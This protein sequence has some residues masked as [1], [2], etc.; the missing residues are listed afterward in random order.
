MGP[1]LIYKVK[2]KRDFATNMFEGT[3][4]HDAMSLQFVS[5]LNLKEAVDQR[6]MQSKLVPSCHGSFAGFPCDDVSKQH[7]QSRTSEHRNTIKDGSLRTGKVFQELLTW[8]QKDEETE[9]GFLEN[10]ADL[11]LPPLP[12][13]D[14]E[15][16]DMANPKEPLPSNLDYVAHHMDKDA[17]A[18]FLAFGLKPD[19]HFGVEVSRARL[20]MPWIKKKL[21]GK[22]T[23][24]EIT[25]V[26]TDAMNIMVGSA[27]AYPL[28]GM[29]VEDN[30]TLV[31]NGYMNA[32]LKRKKED[33]PPL[34]GVSK[35][36]K[37]SSWGV[38]H[39]KL[40]IKRG[41]HIILMEATNIGYIL[42]NNIS[43]TQSQHVSFDA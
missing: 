22:A 43:L 4:H 7:H 34:S 5:E 3:P 42:F 8:F 19:K 30:D 9:F 31:L 1:S 12:G 24:V 35:R 29:L 25:K 40:A 32:D 27:Q 13:S 17:E 23:T 10:V 41:M 2:S 20:W 21:F 14:S 16:D 26:M 15:T 38:T 37:L 33:S 36:L 6:D 28:R 39:A 18:F 11:A